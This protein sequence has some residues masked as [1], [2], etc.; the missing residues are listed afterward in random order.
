MKLF[1]KIITFV[2]LSVIITSAI[3]H[4]ASAKEFNGVSAESACLIE[5]Q[6]GKLLYSKQANKRMPMA[7]TT[8]IMTAIVAIESEIPLDRVVSVDK[9]AVGVEGSSIYLVEGERITFEALLYALLLESAND[10]AVAIALTV[11]NSVDDF[12]VLMNQKASSLGLSNTHF[13]NPHGLFDEDHYT[14]ASDLASIMAYAM[15]NT[16]F[17]AICGCTKMTIPLNNDGVR[18]LINHNRLLKTYEG[19]IGGKTGFTKKSGRCLVSCA[20]RDGLRL[21]AVTLNAPNDWNDH[22]S[23]YDFGFSNYEMVRFDGVS[24][25]VPVISGVCDSVKASSLDSISILMSRQSAE[26]QTRI[27]VP[28]FLYAGV[29]KGDRV[30]RIIYIQNGKIIATSPIIAN[31]DVAKVKYRFNLFEWLSDLLKDLRWK[32]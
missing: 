13:T 12:V 4:R 25:S 9:R 30:G 26:I 11:C 8:K 7:S 23:L 5:A 22:T 16:V 6:S 20:E 2:L 27:E 18:V 21:I 24:L 32:R 3:P 31:E 15:E 28:R 14:T 19:V 1:T 17:A 10:A 29:K